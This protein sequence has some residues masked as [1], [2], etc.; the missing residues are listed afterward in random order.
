VLL[1]GHSLAALLD[2]GAHDTTL[3]RRFGTYWHACAGPMPVGRAH[4]NGLGYRSQC[5]RPSPS[6]PVPT[7]PGAAHPVAPLS[8]RR[9][10]SPAGTD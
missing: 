6:A 7:K 10:K 3:V 1:L 9:R 2:D 8:W 5:P 4:A